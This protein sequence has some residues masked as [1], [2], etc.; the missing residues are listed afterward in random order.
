MVK[1][2]YLRDGSP[3]D[4]ETWKALQADAG[5]V[6]VQKTMLPNGR[7]ISTIWLGIDQREAL[8]DDAPFLFE[9][10]VFDDAT[11]R[12]LATLKH[13]SEADAVTAHQRLIEQ[14][15]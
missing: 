15:A 12:P 14:W 4:A 1:T 8:S 13:T 7:W 11:R 3:T 6:Q 9:S 5:Y 10:V 2:Y